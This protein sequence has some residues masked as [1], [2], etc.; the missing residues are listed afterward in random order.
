MILTVLAMRVPDSFPRSLELVDFYRWSVPLFESSGY[1]EARVLF[2]DLFGQQIVT[3]GQFSNQPNHHRLAKFLTR[4][5]MT[6]K[7]V[8]R[9]ATAFSG[10]CSMDVVRGNCNTVAYRSIHSTSRGC[11]L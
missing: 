1:T 11:D 2:Q 10:G 6:S 8:P 9:V 4:A 7:G 5:R 3:V